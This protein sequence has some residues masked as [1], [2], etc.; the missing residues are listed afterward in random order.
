MRQGAQELL[1]HGMVKSQADA[2]RYFGPGDEGDSYNFSYRLGRQPVVDS[3]WLDLRF[4]KNGT[5][6]RYYI[7]AD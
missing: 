5:L 3:Y 7:R 4:D 1:A 2:L 6:N